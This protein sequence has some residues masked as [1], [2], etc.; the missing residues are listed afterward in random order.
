MAEIIELKC[1]NCGSRFDPSLGVGAL[2]CHYCGTALLVFEERGRRRLLLTGEPFRCPECGEMDRVQKV[3]AICRAQ[4]DTELGRRLRPPQEPPR[5]Y[6]PSDDAPQ[7]PPRWLRGCTSYPAIALLIMVTVAS[8]V[9]FYSEITYYPPGAPMSDFS[10]LLSLATLV[11]FVGFVPS[12]FIIVLV[13][14]IL[15]INEWFAPRRAAK[16]AAKRQRY[17]GEMA[18]W[19]RTLSRWESLYYCSRNDGVFMPGEPILIPIDEAQEYTL[20]AKEEK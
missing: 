13:K 16:R 5:Q 10:L 14:M 3:S 6:L 9:I 4:P 19:K 15:I 2:N 12:L 7:P 8:G 18:K 1:P 11:C 17:E 20:A